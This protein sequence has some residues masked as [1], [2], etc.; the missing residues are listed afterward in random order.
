MIEIFLFAKNEE[1][2][3]ST[4]IN[5]YANLVDKLTIIDNG[6]IDGTWEIMQ[7][8]SNKIDKIQIYRHL[9][10]FNYKAQI[11]TNYMK[12]SSC[13][14]LIPLDTDEIIAYE[15]ENG[16]V[17]MD[18]KLMR[19]YLIE[20][21]Q[22]KIGKLKIKQIYNFIPDTTNQFSLDKHEKFIFL[23]SD[24]KSVDTGF[25]KGQTLEKNS[26]IHNT[27]LVYLHFHFRSFDAWIKST[28]QKLQF[29]L[30]DNWDN[31]DSLLAY[32]KPR[33]S[34]HVALEYSNYL[35]TGKW[36]NLKPFKQIDHNIEPCPKIY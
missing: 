2:F 24:F 34:H 1:D 27:N 30:G 7:D 6:S 18:E 17:Y 10:P 21:S 16:K 3:I 25:H 14:L 5:Y 29:R 28:K 8:L 36:H 32:K 23:G 31:I 12:R 9:E 19:S 22:L 20:L 15:D 33:P 26:V 4:F 11:L 35:K 13:Q